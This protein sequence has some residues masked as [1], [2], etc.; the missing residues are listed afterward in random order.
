MEK[1]PRGYIACT[2]WVVA[3][4][5]IVYGTFDYHRDGTPAGFAWGLFA[6]LVATTVTTW[7]NV[8]KCCHQREHD[9]VTVETIVEVVDA[10]A[11]A[12]EDVARLISP[13]P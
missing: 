1:M 4:A 10:L 3:F 12:K 5:L 7:L 13:R 6:S 2:L 8:E 11:S 9:A